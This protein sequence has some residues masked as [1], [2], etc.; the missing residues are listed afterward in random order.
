M[1]FGNKNKTLTIIL[2]IL[3]PV[4]G[5]AGWLIT[6][7]VIDNTQ[8]YELYIDGS[9]TVFKI[10]DTAQYAF[11]DSHPGVITTI[12]G[13]GTGA[14]ITSLIDGEAHIAMASR[15]VKDIE[16]ESSGFVLKSFA[17]AKDGLA[18]IVNAAASPLD[19]TIDEARAIFNGSVID[20]SDPIVSEAGL[21]G[22]I[23]LVVREDGS[24][25]RDAFNELVM[26][27]ADQLEP[28]SDYPGTELPKN[29]NQLIKDAV[30]EN[31]NYIGYVGLGYI[32]A[33]VDAV[34]ING[35]TPTIDTVQNG[36]YDIQRDLYLVTKGTPTGL[37]REFI[38][39]IFSPD[40]QDIVLESG[41]IN[42]AAT[43]DEIIWKNLKQKIWED[44]QVIFSIY[45]SLKESG[46][47]N[48]ESWRK[49]R[50]YRDE[51]E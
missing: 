9:T 2:I 16:N 7:L 51:R 15:P 42:V 47:W 4:A 13:T 49:K 35:T 40:G 44:T 50:K 45:L 5:I 20:W 3:I 21:T 31:I 18:I 26:G 38:N 37:A 24:S 12:S 25:T 43:S 36:E 28:G 30:A 8:S 17:I 23:Q 48:L 1:S 29:S 34:I 39:W 19:I 27:D 32:D 14:G 41:F 10:V 33:T 46:A 6:S 22:T 11:M